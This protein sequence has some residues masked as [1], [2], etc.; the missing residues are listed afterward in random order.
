[1]SLSFALK[2][3]MEGHKDD[4]E[5]F[6]SA[7][8]YHLLLKTRRTYTTAGLIEYFGL[9]KPG[10]PEDEEGWLIIKYTY[11][12]SLQSQANFPDGE[13]NFEKIWSSR[14]SYSFS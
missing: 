7:F 3:A 12:S 6:L 4:L 13:M 8:E 10:T 5:H 1:M 14:A 11:S 2:K 9:A